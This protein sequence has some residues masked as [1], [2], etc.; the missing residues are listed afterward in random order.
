M[1]VQPMRPYIPK[2]SRGAHGA[3]LQPERLFQVTG[4]QERLVGHDRPGGAIRGDAP[5][6]QHYGAGAEVQDQVQVVGG[7]DQGMLE[8]SSRAR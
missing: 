4:G 8:R 3:A 5:L 2:S 1:V 7:D 6:L